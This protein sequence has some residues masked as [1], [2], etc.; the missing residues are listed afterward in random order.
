M[1]TYV[2][3]SVNEIYTLKVQ[4]KLDGII[5]SWGQFIV[6]G[7]PAVRFKMVVPI[8]TTQSCQAKFYWTGPSAIFN[9]YKPGTRNIDGNSFAQITSGT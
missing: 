6:T 5:A 1:L 4:I 3:A 7:L 8:T 9:I 2:A